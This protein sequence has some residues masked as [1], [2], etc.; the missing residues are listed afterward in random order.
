MYVMYQ[1]GAN[2]LYSP[3]RWFLHR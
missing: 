2:V 3:I 1:L